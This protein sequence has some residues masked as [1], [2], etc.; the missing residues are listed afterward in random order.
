[1]LEID[2]HWFRLVLFLSSCFFVLEKN[3][4][5]GNWVDE[6]TIPPCHSPM[7][8]TRDCHHQLSPDPMGAPDS[9]PP[10]QG[11]VFGVSRDSSYEPPLYQ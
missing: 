4:W 7:E 9:S 1:M 8:S 6:G 2:G 3:H 10:G 11:G 5:G